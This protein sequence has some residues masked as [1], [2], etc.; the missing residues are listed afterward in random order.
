MTAPAPTTPNA[1]TRRL[2]ER[3]GGAVAVTIPQL[4]LATVLAFG[5]GVFLTHVDGNPPFGLLGALCIAG[6]ALVLRRLR[7]APP[8]SAADHD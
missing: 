1:A 7:P 6:D 3:Y 4:L 8:S 5:S 2:H